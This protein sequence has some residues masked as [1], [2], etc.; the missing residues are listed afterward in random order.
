MITHSIDI[1]S[2]YGEFAGRYR[3]PDDGPQKPGRY[4]VCPD[5]RPFINLGLPRTGEAVWH[6]QQ[7]SDTPPTGTRILTREQ[8]VLKGRETP[9]T[10]TEGHH[11]HVRQADHPHSA[12]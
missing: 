6:F 7:T 3:I 10:T 8:L 1:W 4:L 2:H 12:R 11:H 5:G 9:T